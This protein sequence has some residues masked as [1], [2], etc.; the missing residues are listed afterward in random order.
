M[1]KVVE[2]VKMF[3]MSILIAVM[4]I[5]AMTCHA[6]NYSRPISDVDEFVGT[7]YD[8]NGNVALT[9]GSDYSINGCKILSVYYGSGNEKYIAFVDTPLMIR[10]NEGNRTRDIC[11]DG[12]YE[13][14]NKIIIVDGKMGLHRNKNIQHF[15]S[16]GGIYLGM[17]QNQ[18][19]SLYGN[20]SS[21][22]KNYGCVTTWKYSKDGFDVKFAA[23]VVMSIKIYPSGNRKFDWSGLSARNSL[24]DFKYK[25]NASTRNR[26]VYLRIGHGEAI[27]YSNEYVTLEFADPRD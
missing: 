12:S 15:E 6:T 26:R 13:Q 10:I 25:Y 9:I 22:V 3:V 27:G 21:K 19:L 24:N 16:I 4:M 7:W 20:P 5:P 17:S 11:I 23:D 2:M 18:V 1:T 8:V 14:I